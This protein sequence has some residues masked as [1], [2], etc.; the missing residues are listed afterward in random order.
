MGND[1]DMSI[2][3]RRSRDRSFIQK[4]VTG[5]LSIKFEELT[6]RS[7]PFPL[8]QNIYD[9]SLSILR[10]AHSSLTISRG[11]WRL[12]I[13]ALVQWGR[14]CR[15]EGNHNPAN[16]KESGCEPDDA[17]CHLLE[18]TMPLLHPSMRR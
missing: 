16:A 9:L 12:V 14:R 10:S 3:V 13:P 7:E 1:S 17:D 11:K 15:D 4:D 18:P 6:L 2:I 5:M 8:E